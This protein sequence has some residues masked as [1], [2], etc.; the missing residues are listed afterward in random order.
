VSENELSGKWHFHTQSL[1]S[2]RIAGV[3]SAGCRMTAA[4]T[5]PRI[6]AIQ[7]TTVNTGMRDTASFDLLQQQII[8][9]AVADVSALP[10]SRTA[11]LDNTNVD[12]K[13]A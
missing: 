7:A 10:N 8:V 4:V 6:T 5:R 2:T 1:S 3:V 11:T 13:E 9:S 12:F